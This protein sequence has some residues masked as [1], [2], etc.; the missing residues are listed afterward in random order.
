[1]KSLYYGRQRDH[2]TIKRTIPNLYYFTFE[3][4]NVQIF[5]QIP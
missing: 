1:M 3:V 5:N 2:K 4:V